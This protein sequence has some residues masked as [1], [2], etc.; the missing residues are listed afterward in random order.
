MALKD[1]TSNLIQ[2]GKNFTKALLGRLGTIDPEKK[3]GSYLSPC[4]MD[5]YKEYVILQRYYDPPIQGLYRTL[6]PW[7]KYLYQEREWTT[8]TDAHNTIE[9]PKYMWSPFLPVKSAADADVS[10]IMNEFDLKNVK[11]TKDGET[12]IVEESEY[13][14]NVFREND[15]QQFMSRCFKTSC[16]QRDAYI[17]TVNTSD[18]QYKGRRYQHNVRLLLYPPE[19]IFPVID[20]FD[21]MRAILFRCYYEQEVLE[22]ISEELKIYQGIKKEFYSAIW[23]GGSK[24]WIDGE[25]VEDWDYNYSRIPMVHFAHNQGNEYFGRS[26]CEDIIDD[27]DH[28]NLNLSSMWLLIKRTVNPILVA[29]GITLSGDVLPHPTSLGPIILPVGG[30]GDLI[31]VVA[32]IAQSHFSA[33]QY[34]VDLVR[35]KLPH[36]K[37]DRKEMSKDTAR[38]ESMEAMGEG[39]TKYAQDMI[40]N[41]TL[42]FNELCKVILEVWKGI[43]E[44]RI[45]VTDMGPPM[46][47]GVM[48]TVEKV[49]T[50]VDKFGQFPQ[51]FEMVL[52]KLG[53]DDSETQEM[54]DRM[55]EQEERKNRPTPE[56]EGLEMSKAIAGQIVKNKE[57][58]AKKPI[59]EELPE[60][61]KK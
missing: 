51:L 25:Q 37:L 61:E 45:I 43:K 11:S 58:I 16:P 52:K 54:V 12:E 27:I 40:D 53:V 47:E 7:K 20:Q 10:A 23:E 49:G 41:Y 44:D 31:P 17:R 30:D 24:G 57:K 35:E 56:E 3:P 1:Y 59:E 26:S 32:E 34:F 13:L 50:V 39:Y 33:V 4:E 19:Q 15:F 46:S 55:K 9:L 8:D 18:S 5:R 14:R 29:R 21:V 42:A 28:I 36:Y 48:D 22:E 38:P 6:L 2:T 60:E